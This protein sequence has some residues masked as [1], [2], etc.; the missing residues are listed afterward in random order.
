MREN[1]QAMPQSELQAYG[2]AVMKAYGKGGD[3][4]VMGGK[5]TRNEI[6][7]ELKAIG[8]ELKDRVERVRG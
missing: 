5:M 7:A 8:V 3:Q 4:T 2:A 6:V 1:L